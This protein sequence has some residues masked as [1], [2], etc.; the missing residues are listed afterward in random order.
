MCYKMAKIRK[1]RTEKSL[2][3]KV[4]LIIAFLISIASLIGL[5]YFYIYNLLNVGII[6]MVIS[7]FILIVS[8]CLYYSKSRGYYI[9]FS[10][11][12]Y[13]KDQSD[14]NKTD[15]ESGKT[16]CKQIQKVFE[17]E[18]NKLSEPSIKELIEYITKF[19]RISIT[20]IIK[21]F[22]PQSVHDKTKILSKISWKTKEKTWEEYRKIKKVIEL[23]IAEKKLN[24]I[25]KQLDIELYFINAEQAKH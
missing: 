17:S 2:I 19:D 14:K 6:L 12:L 5:Y 10:P 3:L 11:S 15:F 25:L 16:E 13:E 23:L 4:I 20:E 18:K 7:L 21:H 1:E 8:I 24:G 22:Y 9:K